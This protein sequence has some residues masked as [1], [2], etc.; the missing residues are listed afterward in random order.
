[1]KL[2]VRVP[3]MMEDGAIKFV[4]GCCGVVICSFKPEATEEEIEETTS[5][6]HGRVLIVVGG[7][8]PQS[9]EKLYDGVGIK[10]MERCKCS[11]SSCPLTQIPF[12]NSEEAF[13]INTNDHYMRRISKVASNVFILQAIGGI[14]E[15][16]INQFV[17]FLEENDVLMAITS[18]C[19]ENERNAFVKCGWKLTER[20]HHTYQPSRVLGIL[21]YKK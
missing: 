16:E 14:N 21:S 8:F 18:Q 3:N 11:Y 13:A 19:Q 7:K 5:K 20:I 2:P 9:V 15:K 1:M 17:E 10:Q 6:V 4:P 12:R